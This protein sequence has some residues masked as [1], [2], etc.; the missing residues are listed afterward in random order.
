MIVSIGPSPVKHKRFRV[1]M[2]SGKHYD[3][4]LDTGSTYIDHGDI[5]KRAAYRARHLAN[6][7]EYILITNRVPSPALFSY[8]LLWG[9][10]TDI[11]KNIATLNRYWKAKHGRK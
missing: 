4:G 1:I 2:D 11:N 7:T 5:T 6:A 8:Q 10:S 3:F 9:D